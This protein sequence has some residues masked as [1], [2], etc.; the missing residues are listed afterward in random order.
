MR[1]LFVSPCAAVFEQ[2]RIK[3]LNNIC[4]MCEGIYEKNK[5]ENI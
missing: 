4:I 5:L 1:F 3:S 2:K